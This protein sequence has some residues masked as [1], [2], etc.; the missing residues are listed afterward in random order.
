[1]GN[2]TIREDPKTAIQSRRMPINRGPVKNE[3]DIVVYASFHDELMWLVGRDPQ[4]QDAFLTAV[5]ILTKKFPFHKST[6]V[7]YRIW[8]RKHPFIY[9]CPAYETIEIWIKKQRATLHDLKELFTTQWD[10]GLEFYVARFQTVKEAKTLCNYVVKNV[11]LT[12]R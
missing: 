7:D 3:S 4:I 8:A 2:W 12:W 1:M 11:R 10:V 6:R 9:L 5:K